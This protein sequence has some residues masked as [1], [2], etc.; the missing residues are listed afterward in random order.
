ME[1]PDVS[2]E[3]HGVDEDRYP[4]REIL[5]DRF[6]QAI[7]AQ[8]HDG[9]MPEPGKRYERIIR[10]VDELAAIVSGEYAI[11][12]LDRSVVDHPLDAVVDEVIADLRQR[13]VDW[14]AEAPVRASQY[15]ELRRREEQAQA[16]LAAER[17][18]S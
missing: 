8:R 1:G 18:A 11:N 4:S 13:I 5:E 3:T 17:K 12:D 14:V 15:E 16:R 2:R 9:I 7:W 6:V 10:T